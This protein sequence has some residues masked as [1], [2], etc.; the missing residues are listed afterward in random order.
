MIYENAILSG[1]I[2]ISGSLNVN[3]NDLSNGAVSSS[4]STIAERVRAGSSGSR[5]LDYANIQTGSL[6]YNT[7]SLALEAFTGVSASW[8][9]PIGSASVQSYQLPTYTVDF[10]VVAGGGASNRYNGGGAGAGGLRTSWGLPTGNSGG[11]V[12]AE[13]KISLIPNTTYTITVGAGGAQDDASAPT[14]TNDGE[15][16]SISVSGTPTIT[17]IGGGAAGVRTGDATGAA[18]DGGSGG[19]GGSYSSGGYLAGSGTSGQGFNGANGVDGGA[20]QGGGGGGAS[21]AGTVPN[22]GNGLEVSIYDSA[23]TYAGGGGAGANSSPG[24]GGAGGGASGTSSYTMNN[25]AVNTGGGGGGGAMSGTISGG[26]GGSGIVI[27]RMLTSK[28]TGTTTGSPT[29][30][31]DGT[32]TIL[33][34]NSSGTYTA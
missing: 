2:Q 24:S 30:A 3:S 10:L 28:Y 22:G 12:A 8:W 13:S 1:S 27:L 25:G 11:G 18:R 33:V 29:V 19:G 16:S 4:Y 31:T 14:S 5:P 6:W 26:N 17:S 21:A 15:D 23:A 32:D 7:D 20:Y 9:Q 34:F